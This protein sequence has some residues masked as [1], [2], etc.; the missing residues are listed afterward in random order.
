[1]LGAGVGAGGEVLLD[2]EDAGEEVGVE[3][4]FHDFFG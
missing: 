3:G 2:F 4:V 1:M